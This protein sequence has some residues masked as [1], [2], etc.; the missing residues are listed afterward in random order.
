[1]VIEGGCERALPL[2]ATEII[3]SGIH[4]SCRP[5]VSTSK[6]VTRCTDSVKHVASIIC[7]VGRANGSSDNPTLGHGPMV[8]D[9]AVLLGLCQLW[10]HAP[11]SRGRGKGVH[12]EILDL[13]IFR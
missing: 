12:R 5:L 2:A 9:D 6:Q 8:V 4:I 7:Q 1:M 13:K 10:D 11:N 3:D